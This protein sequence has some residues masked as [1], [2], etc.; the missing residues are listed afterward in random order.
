MNRELQYQ[1]FD[2][3]RFPLII[4]V[5]FIH[6]FGKPFDYGALDFTWLTGMDLYNLFRVSISQ[7]LTHVCVPAFFF[8]SGYLFFIGLETWNNGAYLNKLRK[9]CMSLLVPFLIWNTIS[10][11]FPIGG[12]FRHEGMEGVLDFLGKNGYLHLYWDS[13]EWNLDRT[14][15]IGCNNSASSPYLTPLW[16]LRDLM[17]VVICSPI[18]HYYFRKLKL[19]GLFLLFFCYISGVFIPIRGFS[20]MAFLFYGLGA[21][22]CIN[23]IDVTKFTYKYRK[24]IYMIAFL[25]WMLCTLLNGHNTPQ[26]D[27]VYPFWVLIGGLALFNLSTLIVSRGLINIPQQFV[28]GAFFIYLLHTI[29]ING[30]VSWLFINIFGET[31]P[32]LL[33][34]SYFLVPITTVTICLVIYFMLNKYI[35]S[36]CRIL[37]G[38]R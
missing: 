23:R 14:N 25:L 18:L 11:L 2:W 36:L 26:G 6:C 19:F 32:I 33:T 29:K 13:R 15:W 27:I 30:I 4:G 17:I 10:L 37:T 12:A 28:K 31:N 22:F 8:I 7:V 5:V 3:L 9:R 35:P 1:V 34:I 24:F 20:S 38:N 21:Y 16:F